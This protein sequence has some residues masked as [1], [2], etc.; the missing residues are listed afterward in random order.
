MTVRERA[1]VAALRREV[2]RQRRL[3]IELARTL[4]THV[5]TDLPPDACLPRMG[6]LLARIARKK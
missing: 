5:R 6:R 2:H 4:H 3:L 1:A